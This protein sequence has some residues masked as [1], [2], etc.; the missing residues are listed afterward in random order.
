MAS[1]EREALVKVLQI[2]SSTEGGAG[3]AARRLNSALNSIG[4]DSLLLSGTSAKMPRNQH[5]IVVAK[6]FVTRNVSRINTVLQAKLVQKKEFLM[7]PVSL[8]TV[9][10]ERILGLKPDIIHLHTFYNLLST[11]TI[12]RICNSGIPIFVSLHDER[13]YTGGCH[14]AL[15]CFRFEEECLRCPESE[16]L[17][18]GIVFR[19]QGKLV[20]AFSQQKNLTIIAPS[21]WIANRAKGSKVLANSNIV[22]VNN[23]LSLEFISQ[24]DCDQKNK[25]SSSPFL[26]TFVAQDLQNPFK[27]LNTLLECIGKYE[28]EFKEQNIKF[29]F[30]GKGPEVDIGILKAQQYGKIDSSKMIDIYLKS[31]LLIVPSLVDNSPNVIF[32]ALVCGTPFVGSDRTGIPELSA[33][34]GMEFFKFGDSESMFK[35][36]LNQKERKTDPKR[37][38]QAALE[39]VHPEV[40]AKKI[41]ELYWLKST[42]AN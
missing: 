24:S 28:K 4:L 35:A 18:H 1:A 20:R 30:V 36:I 29:I 15:N 7:T 32:E 38:R 6:N 2:A 22:K 25:D 33:A 16:N 9:S 23:P 21:D 26:V 17:F 3:I 5:E 34:F 27:G 42:A 14:H 12:S 8:K 37:I 31:D 11:E 10:V 40:V 13:F 41:A 19:A 39:L